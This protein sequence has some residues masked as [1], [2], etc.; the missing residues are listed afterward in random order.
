[1]VQYFTIK[2]NVNA[3]D[4]VCVWLL[5]IFVETFYQTGEIPL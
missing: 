4:F 2:N 3:K 5:F 1:M